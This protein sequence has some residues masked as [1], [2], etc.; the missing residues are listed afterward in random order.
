MM[1]WGQGY[2]RYSECVDKTG[3]ITAR[4][5]LQGP[6]VHPQAADKLSQYRTGYRTLSCVLPK[7]FMRNGWGKNTIP[8]PQHLLSEAV[9]LRLP[10]D[11]A[12]LVCYLLKEKLYAGTCPHNRHNVQFGL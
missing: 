3:H 2:M 12:I 5:E 4:L 11:R 9:C 7:R 1:E 6:P 8:T 10:N